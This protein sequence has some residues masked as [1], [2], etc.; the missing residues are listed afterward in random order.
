MR[1]Q[2]EKSAKDKAFDREKT[3]LHSIIQKKD[4][5][6]FALNSK[7]NGL[8][9]EAESW[10]MTSEILEKYIGIPKEKILEDI[11]RNKKIESFIK[12]MASI[13]RFL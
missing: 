2:K 13:G 8:K 12:P 5:E 1:K 6:I 3:R 10:K 9:L 4:E 11:E 7:I